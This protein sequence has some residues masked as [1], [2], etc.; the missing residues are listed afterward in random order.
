MSYLNMIQVLANLKD[1]PAAEAC[2][3]EWDAQYIH[4]PK[5]NMKGSAASTTEPDSSTTLPSNQSGVKGTKG[6]EELEM[7]HPKYDIRV[8]NAM[9]K[10]YIAEGMLDKAVALKKH[11]KMRG[12]RLNAKTWEIF[13]EH[14]LKEGDLKMAHWCADRAIKKGHSSGRIWVPPREVTETLMGYF[15][16]NRD[17]DGAERYVEALK[18]VQKDLGTLVFEPLLRTYAAAGKKFPG[19]R[20][21]LK[22]ENVEL[23]E[24]ATQLLDS[25]C[26]DK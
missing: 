6:V 20:Q 4:P 12:G 5:K 16:R 14:Y 9:I 2:F 19:M 25:I 11:A 24:E 10:A 26:V 17:V 7:K 13:M 3:K 8:A 18:K 22:I 1:L 21:R 23:G 15:E